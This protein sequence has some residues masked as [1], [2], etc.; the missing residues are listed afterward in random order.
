[1]PKPSGN[2][3]NA[4][5]KASAGL[6]SSRPVLVVR[7]AA[8]RGP[9]SRWAARPRRRSARSA[10]G[11]VTSLRM[12]SA[13]HAVQRALDAGLPFGYAR[14]EIA[15]VHRVLE[16]LEPWGSWLIEHRIVGQGVLHR[17]LGQCLQR[18]R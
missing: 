15:V 9:G 1:M 16:H 10:G 4:A 5:T 14:A 17:A 8:A 3:A 11:A 18:H 7:R 13:L 12:G 2:R 6:T